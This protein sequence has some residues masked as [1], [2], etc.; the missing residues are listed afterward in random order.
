MKKVNRTVLKKV[1]VYICFQ[2]R[3]C[4]LASVLVCHSGEVEV[5]IEYRVP[6]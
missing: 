4:W 1:S 5:P 3:L 6:S 2:H